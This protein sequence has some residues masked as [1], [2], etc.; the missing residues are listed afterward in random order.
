MHQLSYLEPTYQSSTWLYYPLPSLYSPAMERQLPASIFYPKCESTREVSNL[1]WD[2]PPLDPMAPWIIS[3]FVY[4]KPRTVS[5]CIVKLAAC[6]LRLNILFT[7]NSGDMWRL[8]I[9]CYFDDCWSRHIYL[10]GH[11][12]TYVWG[13][14]PDPRTCSRDVLYTGAQ[15]FH[16]AN[17]F[18]LWL[19]NCLAVQT[20]NS[21]ID[22]NNN[23]QK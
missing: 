11:R 13:R 21:A 1:L 3:L 20:V 7:E 8:S 6:F 9:A 16:I 12:D 23:K 18:F 5:S 17:Y 15:Q 2:V 10:N 19:L 4:V 22:N 14:I